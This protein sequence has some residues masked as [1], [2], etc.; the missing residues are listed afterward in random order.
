[1]GKR[2]C[3]GRESENRRD[4][5]VGLRSNNCLLI[6]FVIWVNNCEM[7]I[8]GSHSYRL[9]FGQLETCLGK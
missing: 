1:M 9:L 2:S 3:K 4:L 7:V 5:K 8:V 6:F